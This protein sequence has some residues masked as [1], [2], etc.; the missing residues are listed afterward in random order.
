[1]IERR[2]DEFLRAAFHIA[3][4]NAARFVTFNRLPGDLR[5][6]FEQE[7]LLELWKKSIAY[8]SRRGSWRTFA[9]RVV[10]N[11]LRSEI[12]RMRAKRSSQLRGESIQGNVVLKVPCEDLELR[13]DVRSLLAALPPFDR[14]VGVLL[15]FYSAFETG[16][17]LRI[18][19]ASVYRAIGRLRGAFIEAGLSPRRHKHGSNTEQRPSE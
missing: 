6:D 9:E 8:D 7:L 14:R 18:S 12:R 13:C 3:K 5:R 10:A 1:V 15:C 4:V 17:I 11:R 2:P 19:N 16:R